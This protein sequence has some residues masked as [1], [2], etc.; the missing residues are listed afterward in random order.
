MLKEKD[1]KL[2][3]PNVS[4]ERQPRRPRRRDSRPRKLSVHV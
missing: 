1:S 2:R 3:R 4:P